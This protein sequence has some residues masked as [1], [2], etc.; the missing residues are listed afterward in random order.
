LH[1]AIVAAGGNQTLYR[2][3]LDIQQRL[4]RYDAAVLNNFS[5]QERFVCYDGIAPGEPDFEYNVAGHYLLLDLLRQHDAEAIE[6]LMH[7]HIRGQKDLAL[8]LLKHEK[9]NEV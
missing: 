4:A 5:L 1:Q 8:A 9:R 2:L 6:K 3:V 7:E